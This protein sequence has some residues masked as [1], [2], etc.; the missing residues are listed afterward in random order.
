VQVAALAAAQR[1]Q[2]SEFRQQSGNPS[3]RSFS[4][5]LQSGFQRH[6]VT[7]SEQSIAGRDLPVQV[8]VMKVSR[9][10]FPKQG[11]T[12]VKRLLLIAAAALMLLNT[13]VVPTV[14][15]T[16]GGGGGGNC[17]GSSICKP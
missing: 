13:L 14:A 7:N 12:T 8:E 10:D 2:I 17:G 16:D 5:I 3:Q 15:Q 9:L 1:A 4:Q 11:E 6:L